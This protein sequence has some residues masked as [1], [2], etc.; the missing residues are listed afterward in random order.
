MLPFLTVKSNAN[1]SG[2]YRKIYSIIPH[3]PGKIQTL[4]LC[5]ATYRESG[6]M[7]GGVD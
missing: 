2:V 4:A 1:G 6:P 3:Y 7:A 5:F